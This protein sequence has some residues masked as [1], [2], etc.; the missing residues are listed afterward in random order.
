MDDDRYN[1]INVDISSGQVFEELLF[2]PAIYFH[3]LPDK[4]ELR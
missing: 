2:Y 1:Y 3:C 4:P